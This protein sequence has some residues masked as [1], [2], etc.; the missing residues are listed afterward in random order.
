MKLLLCLECQDVFKCSTKRVRK[1]AC[2]KTKGKYE[3]DGIH[4]WYS[5]PCVPFGLANNSLVDAI[6][7]PEPTDRWGHRFEAFIIPQ[8]SDTFENRNEKGRR[9]ESVRQSCTRLRENGAAEKGGPITTREGNTTRT[10]VEIRDESAHETDPKAE[11]IR[12]KLVTCLSCG[13]VYFQLTREQAQKQV[14][15]F[16]AWYDQQSEGTKENYSGP[17]DIKSYE[18]CYRCGNHYK[19]FRDTIDDECPRGSTLNPII[20]YE[21]P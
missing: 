9:K 8:N 5:G 21:E 19:A 1:C 15:Q 4:A 2:G 14:D 18:C 10:T 12:S 7:K 3:K 17:A 13:W 16:N 11:V 6:K 20:H